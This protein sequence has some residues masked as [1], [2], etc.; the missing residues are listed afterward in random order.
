MPD[1]WNK[2]TLEPKRQHRWTLHLNGVGGLESYVVKKVDKPTFKINESEHDYFGHKFYYPGQVTW[3]TVSVTL[4][5]PIDPDSSKALYSV[6]QKSG[7]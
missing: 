1:F 5:D 3:E 6:L 7:Y 2:S 4:V